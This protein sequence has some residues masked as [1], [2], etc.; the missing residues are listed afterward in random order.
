[1]TNPDHSEIKKRV[2]DNW[3]SA[4]DGWRRRDALL[5][6]GAA[7]VSSRMLELAAIGPASRLLD[8]AS[9]TGEPAISAARVVGPSGH[10]TGTDLVDEMLA[11]ARDKVASE[12]LDNINFQCV[13]AEE[14]AFEP[15]SFDAV[16]IRWGLMF[17]PEPGACLDRAYRALKPGG[18]ISLACWAAP[19]DNP[20]VGMLIETLSNYMEVPKPPPG[21]PG[22]FAFA[23][24]DRLR[25]V[26]TSAG[27]KNVA[28]EDMTINVIEVADGRAYWE[29]MSDLA[30]PVMALVAQLDEA[31]R[32]NYIDE[33]IKVA[34]GLK[35]GE[36][37]R[38]TGTTW[39]ASAD[40]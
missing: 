38:V 11:V 30:A 34:D 29:A 9:G 28:L 31:R 27:F 16:T 26:I 22:I 24:P 37:L 6:A 14:L 13:D 1:M 39:I 15:A 33:V 5:R 12:G 4:A 19:S 32:L 7:P 40:K 36:S 17:M 35:Q 25:S 23:D 2:H 3:A 20:F 21:A 8:I 18:R 10:V